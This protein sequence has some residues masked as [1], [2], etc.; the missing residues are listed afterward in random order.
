MNCEQARYR[1]LEID[2]R[3]GEVEDHLALCAECREEAA[4]W[5]RLATLPEE[6]PSA[7]LRDRFDAMIERESPRGV[8]WWRLPAWQA[9]A[10]A[11]L[12]IAGW[13]A[14]RSLPSSGDVSQMR[15]EIRD[16]REAV[17]LSLLQQA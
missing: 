9:V 5:D 7:H 2:G 16:L 17:A 11:L 6:R 12:V 3:T 1:M 4:L 8:P 13:A 10:A 14:G 15:R